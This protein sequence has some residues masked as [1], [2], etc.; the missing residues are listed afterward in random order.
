VRLFP[1]AA[2]D[3]ATIDEF[4][5][6]ADFEWERVRDFIVLHYWANRREGEFWKYCRT[7]ELP[8][9]LQHKIDVW[10][11]N[12]RIFREDEE[13]FSEESW[14]QVFLGQGKIPR[15]HDPLVAIKSDPEI[16][17]YLG[18]IAAT[19]ARCVEVMPTHDEYLAKYCPADPIA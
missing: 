10:C 3:H 7:M 17:Q 18:N 11:S 13:L 5:R 8:Q 6:Q 16:E 12:G 14:I 9:T 4:N 15:S 2:T 1:D 19:I